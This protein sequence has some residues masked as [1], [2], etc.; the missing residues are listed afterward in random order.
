M[1]QGGF[2]R[3]FSSERSRFMDALAEQLDAK[4]REW[5]PE[6]AEQVRRRIAE[7]IEVADQNLLD[8]VRSRTVEQEVMGLIDEPAPR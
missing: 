7:V 8:L 1:S 5:T 3:Y 4:L 2:A 6:I